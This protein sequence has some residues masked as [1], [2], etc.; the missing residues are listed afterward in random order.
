[1]RSICTVIACLFLE[2]AFIVN[3]EATWSIVAVDP[4]TGEAG[5]AAATCGLGINFI[6]ESVP[7]V[8]VVAAQAATS[9]KGR[10]QA[11]AWMMDGIGAT[12]ILR[13]LSDDEFYD[14]WF[15]A[16]FADLQYGVATLIGEP[17]AGFVAGD[18]LLPWAGGTAGENYS[19]QGNA[20]RGEQ[21]ITAAASSFRADQDGMCRL[22]LAARL[23]AA[24]EAGRDAG[25]DSRCD[26]N[27]PAQSAMLLVVR[28]P[29]NGADADERA[30]RWVTPF[31]TGLLRGIYHSIIPY[32]A[33]EGGAGPIQ[34]LRETFESTDTNRCKD[35]ASVE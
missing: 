10:D 11:K 26:L 33:E 5:L 6:A 20:L 34:Q 23:I 17:Q 28:G 24:L 4:E 14:G 2:L 25:G 12:E 13:L 1:M 8:G 7:G 21:V 29:K 15:D 31:E 16:E 27:R 35:A 19:V 32:Q 3:A 30:L 18:Q 9:F 22:T